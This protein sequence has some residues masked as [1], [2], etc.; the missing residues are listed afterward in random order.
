[1]FA[2]SIEAYE[3]R[4]LVSPESDDM[5]LYVCKKATRLN[6]TTVIVSVSVLFGD[7]GYFL[8]DGNIFYGDAHIYFNSDTPINNVAVCNELIFHGGE[9]VVIYDAKTMQHF[10]LLLVVGQ[11]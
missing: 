8:Y 4:K 9:N 1:V 5:T 7:E 3:D 6:D 2:D 11:L 10:F